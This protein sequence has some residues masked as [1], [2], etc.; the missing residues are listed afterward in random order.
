MLEDWTIRTCQVHKVAKLTALFWQVKFRELFAA[1]GLR[2]G[3]GLDQNG[4]LQLVKEVMGPDMR[5]AELAYLH[6]MLDAD[7]NNKV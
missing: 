7:G 3:S 1:Y 2:D 5:P 4:L 6:V